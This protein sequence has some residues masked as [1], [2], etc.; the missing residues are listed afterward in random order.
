[1]AKWRG[2]GP[3]MTGDVAVHVACGA[4]LHMGFLDLSFTLG[5]R[6]GSIGMALDRPQTQITL[7][8]STETRVEG[9]ESERAARYLATLTRRLNLPSAHSLTIAAAM[10]AHAGLGSGTQLALGIAAALRRLHGLPDDH[11]ADA[12][13]LGR[14]GRSGIG[15]ALFR[16]GGFVL[17][18]GIGGAGGPPPMLSRVAIPETWRVLLI[19]D[20]AQTGLSGSDEVAAFAALPPLDDAYS[21]EIC[22]L[23]L[24]QV[25]PALVED[26]LARFGAAIS[27]IQV[28]I[29]E[30]FAPVQGGR[31]TSP[32]LAAAL[33]LL[34][35]AGAT[36]AGQSSW[37]P[38]GFAVVDC[39]ATA[40]RLTDLLRQSTRSQGLD[41]TICRPRNYGATISDHRSPITENG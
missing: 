41:I 29:G 28:I 23:V 1:M 3:E 24:M 10:P 14:G 30:Y 19:R 38:A 37:G 16:H 2:T 12:R 31:F 18:G 36:A 25:L 15:L 9:P 13:T 4:R 33:S 8:H 20:T 11:A 22:R 27:R 21:A 40:E 6:F 39:P 17:D 32:R 5:R 26:D 35:D 7:R 34:S